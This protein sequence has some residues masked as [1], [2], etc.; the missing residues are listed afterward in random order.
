MDAVK[1]SVES[2]LAQLRTKLDESSTLQKL[3]VCSFDDCQNII[4]GS[5][6]Q[7]RPCQSNY[8]V[9]SILFTSNLPSQLG[10]NKCSKRILC[11][12]L[13]L[14]P[15]YRVHVWRWHGDS[16]QRYRIRLPRIQICSGYGV[17]CL[18]RSDS[19]ACVLGC[20]CI[21]FGD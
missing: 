12:R 18:E 14:H 4:I 16:L 7:S 2:S 5:C 20:V 8:V 19:V 11:H 10:Q 17:P 13:R 9:N 21:L 3:E 15:P 1:A 6:L